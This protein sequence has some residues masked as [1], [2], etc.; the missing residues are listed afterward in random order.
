MLEGN[1][2]AGSACHIEQRDVK[3]DERA[4]A[5]RWRNVGLRERWMSSRRTMA[6]R[7]S[8]RKSV[9][10]WNVNVGAGGGSR[11]RWA[12]AALRFQRTRC[13]ERHPFHDCLRVC[14]DGRKD[15]GA[16]RGRTETGSEPRQILSLLRL[17]VPPQRHNLLSDCSA[18]MR[19]EWDG[20]PNTCGVRKKRGDGRNHALEPASVTAFNMISEA[21]ADEGGERQLFEH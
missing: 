18:R 9:A 6:A 1:A 15:G 16:A 8:G 12:A 21:E 19:L 14:P 5:P 10:L 2:G 4:P 13:P 17:P 11:S 3:V 20:R 7:K